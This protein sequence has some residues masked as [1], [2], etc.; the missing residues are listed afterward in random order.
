MADDEEQEKKEFFNA[1]VKI[2]EH[3][4]ILVIDLAD[5]RRVS[6]SHKCGCQQNRAT[7]VL[8]SHWIPEATGLVET[9]ERFHSE[10]GPDVHSF[11]FGQLFSL[12]VAT[13]FTR[14]LLFVSEP[15]EFAFIRQQ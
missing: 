11:G 15:T 1:R 3:W 7:D 2:P 8:F 6:L 13:L 5:S 10:Q 12:I 4:A 9:I 14:D